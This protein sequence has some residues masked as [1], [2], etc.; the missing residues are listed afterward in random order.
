M[1]GIKKFN[2]KNKPKIK[3]LSQFKPISQNLDLDPKAGIILWKAN[4]KKL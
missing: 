3:Y 2:C 1:N 4:P